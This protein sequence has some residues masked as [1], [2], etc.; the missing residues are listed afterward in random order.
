VIDHVTLLPPAKIEGRVDRDNF[1]PILGRTISPG[2]NVFVS[3]WVLRSAA[4]KE[5]E[6]GLQFFAPQNAAV[7]SGNAGIE[8]VLGKRF[9]SVT[10]FGLS[11]AR[12]AISV[13][14]GTRPK[15][16]IRTSDARPLGLAAPRQRAP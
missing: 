1:T 5:S 10:V 7:E 2:F 11:L 6:H 16:G 13:S 3:G 15:N 9:P 4:L 8:I 14:P 12:G